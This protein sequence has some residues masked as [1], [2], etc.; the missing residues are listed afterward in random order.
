MLLICLLGTLPA[1]APSAAQETIAEAR[2]E[3]ELIEEEKLALQARIDVLA[4]EDVDVFRA[5]KAAEQLVARQVAQVEAAEQQLRAQVAVQRQNEAAIGWTQLDIAAL[6]Q[7]AEA[8]IVEVYLQAGS[9][10]TAT[11]LASDDLTHGL[12]R[13][14]LLEAVHGHAEDL[15]EDIRLAEDRYDVALAEAAQTVA[16]VER[17]REILEGDL[18]VLEQRRAQQAAIKAELDSRKR[19]IER[20]YAAWDQEASELEQFIR[21]AKYRQ[22]LEEFQ[23]AQEE[24][25]AAPSGFVWPTAGVVSSGYG[26]RLHP[27]LGVYRLHAGIDIG[28]T[29]GQPV[30]AARGGVVV[31]AGPWGGY[32]NA[33]V[34]DHGSGLSSVYAHLS[35]VTARPGTIVDAT[36]LVGNIGSTGL[37]TGPHLHFEIRVNGTAVDPLGYL[38]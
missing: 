3:L 24:A 37:S 34:I 5:L 12:R 28:K 15:V 33:V 31:T 16:E 4:A 14:A 18:A 8:V 7:D 23:R 2:A 17:L 30:H 25:G 26:N 36:N 1:A 6:R 21:E 13:L 38:P 35:Q 19:A 20:E 27:I 11:L 32:G 29:H 22:Q 9:E 10:R